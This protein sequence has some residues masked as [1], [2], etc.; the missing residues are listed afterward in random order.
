[1]IIPVPI[2][3]AT[4]DPKSV[5]PINEPTVEIRIAWLVFTAFVAIIPAVAYAASVKPVQN[6]KIMARIRAKI[7]I[8]SGSTIFQDYVL[9]D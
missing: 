7:R 2:V 1:M 9:D 6:P 8:I 3:L 5:M 4:A